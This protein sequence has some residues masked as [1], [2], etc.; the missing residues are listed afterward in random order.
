M[1]RSADSNVVHPIEAPRARR[2][3]ALDFVSQEVTIRH[4]RDAWQVDAVQGSVCPQCSA[5]V[6]VRVLLMTATCWRC[7]S[8]LDLVFLLARKPHVA[9]RLPAAL[10]AS[11]RAEQPP[12]VARV[13]HPGKPICATR[14]DPRSGLAAPP[15]APQVAATPVADRLPDRPLS[16]GSMDWATP[17]LACLISGLVH[18]AM[19]VLLGML[20][21]RSEPRDPQITLSVSVHRIDRRGRADA[22]GSDAVHVDAA[23][24]DPRRPES[25]E[26][27]ALARQDARRLEM[28]PA[29]GPQ[30]LP[31]LAAVRDTL[32]SPD[33]YRRMLAARDPR[34]RR[35]IVQREGGTTFTEA[36]VARALRWLDHHQHD[37][38]RWSLDGFQEH[39]QCR[40]RCGDAARL[41]SDCGGTALALLTYL[42][43]GQ[44]HQVGVYHRSVRR[45]LDWLLDN[46]QPD[47]DL[48]G[49][50]DLRAGMYVHGQAAIVLCDAL[51]L[52]GD[53]R[54]RGAA[55]RAID[56]ICAAQHAE[57]GWRYVPGQA[58]DLSVVGWQLMALQS[59]RAASLEIPSRT[60]RRA[61]RFLDRAQT[62][63]RGALYAYQPGG[64]PSPAMT[65]E[66]LLSRMYLGWGRDHRGLRRGV[67]LLTTQFPPRMDQPNIYYW[68]YATQVVHHWGGP[69][70]QTWNERMRDVL[71]STQATDGHEAGS[72]DPRTPHG[73]F[74]GRLYMT[75]LAACTLEVYYRHAPLFR[76][77]DLQ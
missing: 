55:Q 22:S 36:A 75:A 59:A 47:G 63:R 76:R 23:R 38:G 69:L 28:I 68:Y 9:S 43:A 29:D 31:R 37:D 30:I 6:T 39:P 18:A 8:P 11:R 66:G 60:M 53:E 2:E 4:G 73:E 5:P 61:E 44:T 27:H 50:G 56:F 21:L 15:G 62:D 42:G 26:A 14:V 65:A 70:W 24:P 35:Q 20:T 46:Q 3:G 51:V 71:V 54:L 7:G 74:G 49:A 12:S 34:L 58:G 72:W 32:A 25:L 13:A 19:I 16:A 77:I 45:G 40:G 33:P 67:R 52:T 41:H 1:A 57:G 10:P 17:L 48:R 64:H